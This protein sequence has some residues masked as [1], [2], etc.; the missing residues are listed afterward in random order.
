MPETDKL[1]TL[2]T[3]AVLMQTRLSNTDELL[4]AYAFIIVTMTRFFYFGNVGFSPVTEL[5]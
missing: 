1:P 2:L 5:A 4:Y 3:I